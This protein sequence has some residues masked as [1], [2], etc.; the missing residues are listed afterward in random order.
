MRWVLNHFLNHLRT[1]SVQQT[2]DALVLCVPC[3]HRYH[4]LSKSGNHSEGFD[5][6]SCPSS[7]RLW[8]TIHEKFLIIYV[9]EHLHCVK[10]YKNNV[11]GVTINLKQIFGSYCED[12]RSRA[13]IQV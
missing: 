7:M 3:K 10:P 8:G 5:I 12:F 9:S 1:E 11:L 13:I 6:K 2:G 4:C